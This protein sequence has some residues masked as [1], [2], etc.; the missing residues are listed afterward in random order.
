MTTVSQKLDD[1]MARFDGFELGVFDRLNHLE[2][3]I[4]DLADASSPG[5][6]DMPAEPAEIAASRREQARLAAAEREKDMPPPGKARS[7]SPR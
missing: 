7:A 3:R 5:G 4:R 6:G 1:L 2:M